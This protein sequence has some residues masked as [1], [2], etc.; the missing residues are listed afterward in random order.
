MKVICLQNIS[1]P[2]GVSVAGETIN[3]SEDLVKDL[4]Q[5]KL[6]KI[7]E[8]DIPPIGKETYSAKVEETAKKKDPKNKKD[9]KRK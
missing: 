7:V 9:K 4:E 2:N 6:V 1:F 5:R 8:E 3:I